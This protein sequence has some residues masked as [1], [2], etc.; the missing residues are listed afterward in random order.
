MTVVIPACNEKDQRIAI[1]PTAERDTI[2]ERYKSKR[3]DDLLVLRNKQPTW[4]EGLSFPQTIDCSF[5]HR[6]K[7]VC[8]ELLWS[9]TYGLCQEFPDCSRKRWYRLHHRDYLVTYLQRIT[10]SCSL[11]VWISRASRWTSN[12]P[13]QHARCV[14]LVVVLQTVTMEQAFSIALS[15]FDGKLACE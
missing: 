14:L 7:L 8:V 15:S 4:N 6:D 1:T 10:S 2:V 11:A 9:R 12:T 13:C 3:L 5:G